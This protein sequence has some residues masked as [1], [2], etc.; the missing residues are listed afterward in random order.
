MKLIKTIST[1]SFLF[2][3]L[4]GN[5]QAQ[6]VTFEKSKAFIS[7]FEKAD[8]KKITWGYLTVPETWGANDG[9]TI[10]IA[11]NG[12]KKEFSFKRFERNSFYTRWS[13]CKW[14]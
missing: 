12:I 5:L 3:I 13:G 4:I 6:N 11:V 10:K 8:P 2:A 9:K 14:Y 7:Q 1:I